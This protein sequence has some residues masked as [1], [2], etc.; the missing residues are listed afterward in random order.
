MPVFTTSINGFYFPYHSTSL[1]TTVLPSS[2]R[3]LMKPTF[4]QFKLALVSGI[5]NN[6]KLNTQS[7]YPCRRMCFNQPHGGSNI[8]NLL[9][10]NL[11]IIS[12]HWYIGQVLVFSF[13]AYMKKKA[14]EDK[15]LISAPILI[16]HYHF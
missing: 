9:A 10:D 8:G 2:V 14:V 4:W 11:I 12:A 5:Q 13:T 16:I 7:P 15:C 3:L 6:R 1:D